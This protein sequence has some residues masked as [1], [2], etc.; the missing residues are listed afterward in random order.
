M[1][2][3]KIRLIDE[4]RS[5]WRWSSVRFIWAAGALEL[6]LLAFPDRISQYV[7]DRIM[8]VAA[9]VALVG[10]FLGRLT[11]VESPNDKPPQPP[12]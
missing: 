3:L 6:T 2:N 8:H 4:W 9:T 11:H 7:P 5:C 1:P 10:A 12:R